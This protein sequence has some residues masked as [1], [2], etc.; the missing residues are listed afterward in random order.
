LSDVLFLCHARPKDQEQQK[1]WSRLIG[2]YC[3]TCWRPMTQHK[4]KHKPVEA[5]LPVPDTWETA[6]SSGKDAKKVWEEAIHKGSLGALAFIRN[7]RN[8]EQAS[9]SPNLIRQ[10]LEGIKVERVLP[11][12]FIVAASHAPK[13]EPE[14]E[15]AMFRCLEGMPKLSGTTALVVDTSPSM[16][17]DQITANSDMTR[18]DAAAALAI[19]VRQVCERVNVY[20]FNEKAHV[21]PARNGFALRDAMAKTKGGYS[22]GG[23]AVKQANADGYDRLIVI[24]DGQWHPM[25]GGV[26]EGRDHPSVCPPPLPNK[27]AYMVDVSV[28]KNG[29]GYGGRWTHINGWSEAILNYIQAVENPVELKELESATHAKPAKAKR[30]RRAKISKHTKPTKSAKTRKAQVD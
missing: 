28:E 27:V 3:E 24:T 12:R 11:F 15:K 26:F 7:L 22:R 17:Q 10:G 5:V 16:W 8:M 21:V 20:T 2:G 29:I 18:F 4:G 19:L 14:L 23:L 9:V 6:L 25:S 30:V 1:L 13:Y